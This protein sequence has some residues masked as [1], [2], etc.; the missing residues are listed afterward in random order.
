MSDAL[1]KLSTATDLTRDDVK[2][3]WADVQA[4]GRALNACTGHS[5]EPV[6]PLQTIRQKYRC[7]VCSGTIDAI[8]HSWY[9]KGRA[10]A[11][12]R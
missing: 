12:S 3:I 10:H 1:D 11:C 6:L 7:T 5:F 4:N 9:E 8:A 2:S